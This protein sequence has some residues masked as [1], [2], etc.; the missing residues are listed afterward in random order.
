MANP[1]HIVAIRVELS[2][3]SVFKLEASK[4]SAGFQLEFILVMKRVIVFFH[5]FRTLR[6]AD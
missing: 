2:E 1:D 6:I 3:R 4:R 5:T